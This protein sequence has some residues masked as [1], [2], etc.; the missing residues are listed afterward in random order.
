[1]TALKATFNEHTG[2]DARVAFLCL[3]R[4]S[5]GITVYWSALENIAVYLCTSVRGYAT[6]FKVYLVTLGDQLGGLTDQP[7]TITPSTI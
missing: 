4:S 5:E 6:H 7:V 1:M 2:F 3:A